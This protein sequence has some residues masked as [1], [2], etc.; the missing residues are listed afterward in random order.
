[1]AEDLERALARKKQ[2]A[3]EFERYRFGKPGAVGE[4]GG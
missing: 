3:L 1:M 4:P 2:A